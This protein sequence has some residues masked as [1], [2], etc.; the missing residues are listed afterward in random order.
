MDIYGFIK[1]LTTE[2]RCLLAK[3]CGVTVTY[4]N[5][6]ASKQDGIS[7]RLAHKILH[8]EFNKKQIDPYR[9]TETQFQVLCN[10]KRARRL[11]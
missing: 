7:Q 3:E 1:I 5:W 8:S 4:L 6:L 11:K 10:E 2:E 9:F